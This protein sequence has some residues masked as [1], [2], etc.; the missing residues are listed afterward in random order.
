MLEIWAQLYDITKDNM[1]LTLIERYDRHRLF[2][3]LLAGEDVLTNMHA[4]TTIPEI[5]GCAAVYEATKITRYRDIVLA[6]WK[7]AVTDRGYFVT[8]GQTNGEIWTPKHRQASRLGER[9]QEHCSVY[10]MIRLA[11]ILFTWTGDVSYLDYIE[12]NLYNGI[13]AQAYWKEDLPNGQISSYPSE[14]L[15]T[16]FLPMRA[17]SRKGWASKTQDFFCCHGSVVQANAA[18]N[19]YLDRTIRMVQIYMLLNISTPLH[20]FQLAVQM[21]L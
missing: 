11:N 12:K 17:G 2:D 1:Y 10:N 7:C 15:L 5:I 19:Q 16:Y 21:L 3:P 20:T 8:G 6:Y 9:N 14:G 4:N 18:H 13:L